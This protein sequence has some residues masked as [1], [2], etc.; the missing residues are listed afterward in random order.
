LHKEWLGDLVFKVIQCDD[1]GV[2]DVLID[3]ARDYL[4]EPV[5]LVMVADRDSLLLEIYGRSENLA[6]KNEVA[7]RIFRSSRSAAALVLLLDVIGPDKRDQVLS[8]EIG[9]ILEEAMFSP[10]STFL[11]APR[12]NGILIAEELATGKMTHAEHALEDK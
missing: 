7:W 12:F 11:P 5:M 10:P 2:R 6:K 1:Y 4:T 3:C 8:E 9:A